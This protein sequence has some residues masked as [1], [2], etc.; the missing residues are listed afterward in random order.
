MFPGPHPPLPGGGRA[1]CGGL[2]LS[3]GRT[4]IPSGG[5][6]WGGPSG[7]GTSDTR[8]TR[9]GPWPLV[10]PSRR[11]RITDVNRILALESSVVFNPFGTG[12]GGGVSGDASS[13]GGEEDSPNL[14]VLPWQGCS[15]PL[16][17]ATAAPGCSGSFWDRRCWK[18]RHLNGGACSLC[19]ALKN[20]EG[21]LKMTGSLVL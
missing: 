18:S 17:E 20:R 21:A 12:S 14:E 2:R 15:T 16:L 7:R 8:R 3:Q 9:L 10:P 1:G 5:C 19:S 4:P 11:G 13:P 6:V